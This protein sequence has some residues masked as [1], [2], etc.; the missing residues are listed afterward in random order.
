MTL[1]RLLLMNLHYR[2]Q[3]WQTRHELTFDQMRRLWLR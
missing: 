2:I 3:E 1:L